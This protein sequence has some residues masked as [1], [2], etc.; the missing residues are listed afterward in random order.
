LKVITVPTP[1]AH[2]LVLFGV[3]DFFGSAL[4]FQALY[5]AHLGLFLHKA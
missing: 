1:P 2:T 3:D 5:A 4:A